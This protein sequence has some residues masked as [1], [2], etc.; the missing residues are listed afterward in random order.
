MY[1]HDVHKEISMLRFRR[2]P[3]RKLLEKLDWDLLAFEE[4]RVIFAYPPN[5]LGK[6]CI[7]RMGRMR[8]F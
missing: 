6:K 1:G 2:L 4:K 8:I 7:L 3:G 5:L